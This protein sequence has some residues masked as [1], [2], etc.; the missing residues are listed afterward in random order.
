MPK[1]KELSATDSQLNHYFD[2]IYV[3][4]LQF[5]VADRLIITEHLNKHEIDFEIFN[6]TNGYEGEALGTFQEYQKRKLGDLKRYTKHSKKEKLR[7]LPFIESAGAIGY[8]Y[9]YLRIL[10]DAKKHG[11]KRFLILEDDVLLSENFETQ[12]KN[13][14]QNVDKD[15]KILLFGASQYSWESV[16][17][18]LALNK[19][20]YLPRSL[21]TCGSFAIAFDFSIVDELIEAESAFEAPF[22]HLPMGEMYEKYLEKCFVAYPNIIIPDVG[23]SLIR[24][25]RNQY[26]HSKKMKWPLK[27]FDYPLIKPSI[28]VI[29]TSKDNL[30]YYSNFSTSKNLP[31]SLKLFFNSSDGLRPLHN[32]ELLDTVKNI[33]QPIS[34]DIYIPES[35]YVVTINKDEILTESDLIKFL[36]YKLNIREKNRTPLRE[37]EFLQREVIKDRVS[38]IIPTYKRP[39]NLKNALTSVVI[40]DYPD[41]EVI[42]I[43][44]NG[45]DSEFNEETKQIVYSFYD[46]NPNCNVILLEH[47]INRN[48]AAAR[49]TGIMHATGEYFCFLDDDDMY[50]PG[51]LSKSITKLKTTSKT[52]AAVY[53]G[54]L[55]WN[56]SKNDLNRYKTGDLTLDILLL[57]YKTHYLHTNTATYRR[58]AVL[59]IN[60]FDESYRRHQDLEFNL[61]YFEYYTT[62]AVKECL[63]R[64]R[65][66]PSNINNT[67]HDLSMLE[68]KEKILNQFSYT[69]QRYNDNTIASIYTAH[70][71]EV[72]RYISDMNAFIDKAKEDPK[73]GLLHILHDIKP[74]NE[75]MK[76]IR[77]SSFSEQ[78]NK[79][80]NKIKN[81]TAYQI[82]RSLFYKYI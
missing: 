56:S 18:S 45:K 32:I 36:E 66:A 14:I 16:D 12:F 48:G 37:I 22:D 78:K 20:F 61:R 64:L 50:L 62:E 1:T 8:I 67:V 28:S 63:V 82:L 10:E 15:W 25:Q 69:I 71:L 30:K 3:V 47:H 43:S 49:N 80:K 5:K 44:D 40:Q 27:N 24:G 81:T 77:P 23:D 68:L 79:I 72:K 33:I 31:F 58:E 52:T 51:R 74:K 70:W 4:N 54:F 60:G 7:G 29:I 75:K 6:A 2:H 11:Y 26:D 65:P 42:V 41:I 53:C 13:F 73:E 38:V 19:G 59:R 9:T 46:Q 39:E 34:N 76:I 17:L 21:D 35:T 55:G 57:N